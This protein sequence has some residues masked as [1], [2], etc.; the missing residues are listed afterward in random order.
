MFSV[1]QRQM[2]LMLDLLSHKNNIGMVFSASAQRTRKAL[3]CEVWFCTQWLFHFIC[4][5]WSIP[6]IKFLPQNSLDCYEKCTF[7]WEELYQEIL[8]CIKYEG[9]LCKCNLCNNLRYSDPNKKL[10]SNGFNMLAH[11][12]SFNATY[13]PINL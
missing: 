3:R 7:I 12:C 1:H 13:A 6:C 4:E 8:F 11:S 2:G 5:T 9:L 10:W